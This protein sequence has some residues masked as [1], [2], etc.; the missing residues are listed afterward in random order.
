M[1]DQ[2]NSAEQPAVVSATQLGTIQGL[3]E[4]SEFQF[5]APAQ[6]IEMDD[7]G[8]PQ[9]RSVEDTG[10]HPHPRLPDFDLQQPQAQ[11]G[12]PGLQRRFGP[13]QHQ[14]ILSVCPFRRFRQQADIGADPHQ[15][16]VTVGEN[17]RHRG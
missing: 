12:L 17:L 14:A 9:L 11:R 15:E 7:L 5:D 6:L 8:P 13:A 4:A 10:Q 16:V 1:R 2:C 3:L